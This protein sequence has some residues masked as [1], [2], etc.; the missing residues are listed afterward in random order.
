M[1]RFKKKQIKI[2]LNARTR[3]NRYDN[4]PD[5]INAEVIGDF[6]VHR[7]LTTGRNYWVVTHVP[8][9]CMCHGVVGIMLKRDARRLAEH[10]DR[11]LPHVECEVGS[12]EFHD[13]G[14]LVRRVRSEF[15]YAN[16]NA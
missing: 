11:N 12:Q 14:K 10:Y 9:G 6:A 16:Y 1:A 5:A 8:S 13:F 4:T 3:S 15:P 2:H 7:T